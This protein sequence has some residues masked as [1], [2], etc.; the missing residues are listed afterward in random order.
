MAVWDTVLSVILT[1]FVMAAAWLNTKYPTAMFFPQ[2]PQLFTFKRRSPPNPI[3]EPIPNGAAAA[4][5]EISANGHAAVSDSG[6]SSG[7]DS[8]D[9]VLGKTELISVQTVLET[10]V[11][12][13]FAGFSPSWW[14][15]NGHLQTG[16]VVA[17]N[18]SKVDAI[19]YERCERNLIPYLFIRSLCW[20]VLGFLID[21][22][23]LSLLL[24]L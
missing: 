20:L 24:V 23:A 3:Q 22:C 10:R 4:T 19:M 12:S 5:N 7:I 18:F 17:G 6:A 21:H 2:K 16:Y 9:A 15:P 8:N 11:P 1:P 13:L 14:L